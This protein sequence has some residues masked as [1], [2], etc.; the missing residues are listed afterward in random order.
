M[1]HPLSS[2]MIALALAFA[3][4]FGCD[5]VVPTAPVPKVNNTLSGRILSSTGAPLPHVVV[6]SPRR[7]ISDTTGTDGRWSL[8]SDST[9]PDSLELFLDEID[10]GS[11]IPPSNSVSHDLRL[12]RRNITGALDDPYIRYGNMLPKFG[13]STP[14][15]RVCVLLQRRNGQL[16]QIPAQ[17]DT[18][19]GNISTTTW[20]IDGERSQTGKYWAETV[21]LGYV[22]GRSPVDSF[23]A[24]AG[25]LSIAK[26]FPRNW[27][28]PTSLQASSWRYRDTVTV[29]SGVDTPY[30][31]QIQWRT[32]KDK[33][34]RVGRGSLLVT[35]PS[36]L[37]SPLVVEARIQD[38]EGLFHP[39]SQIVFAPGRGNSYLSPWRIPTPPKLSISTPQ[40]ARI[41]DSIWVGSHVQDTLGGRIVRR[42]IA[43]NWGDTVELTSD[44]QK[45]YVPDRRK[46]GYLS[47]DVVAV[48]NDAEATSV[49]FGMNLQQPGPQVVVTNT[50]LTGFDVEWEPIWERSSYSNQVWDRVHIKVLDSASGSI[51]TDTL[52]SGSE[53]VF[54]QNRQF[55]S[56]HVKVGIRFE[57]NYGDTATASGW[58]WSLASLP[59]GT[60]NPI[61][62]N[63]SQVSFLPG[64]T[65]IEGYST[66]PLP[67]VPLPDSG[68]VLVA[69][70]P[71]NGVRQYYT[72]A[73]WGGAMGLQ[74]S[75]TFDVAAVIPVRIQVRIGIFSRDTLSTWFGWEARTVQSGKQTFRLSDLRMFPSADASDTAVGPYPLGWQ[76]F[77]QERLI[78]LGRKANMLAIDIPCSFPLDSG[79]LVRPVTLQVYGVDPR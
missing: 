37:D 11:F 16:V 27:Q 25:D 8:V 61:Q 64:Q 57:Y 44:S 46:D 13:P 19:T 76:N 60:L 4:L 42:F 15:Y 68:V 20:F 54:H 22:I 3:G 79:C 2:R 1:K 12:V 21:E 53:I 65:Q 6:Y 66:Y 47:G 40:T 62:L 78:G 55:L 48:D 17:I 18:L 29:S 26:F 38:L 23:D 31:K 7:Q 59:V 49:S 67:I 28:I 9:K 58:G 35:C 71:Q 33:I 10:V 74:D 50:V 24:S 41:R 34:W 51:L 69:T 63:R 56:R 52:L 70:A 45:V 5:Q 73:G 75:I 72:N 77:T 36:G 32:S 39:A 14:T 43:W 30:V